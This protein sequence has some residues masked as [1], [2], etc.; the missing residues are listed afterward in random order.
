EAGEE[1]FSDYPFTYV[2]GGVMNTAT[3]MQ[4]L[5]LDAGVYFP[6]ENGFLGKALQQVVEEHGVTSL[7]FDSRSISASIVFRKKADRGFLASAD[8]SGFS[9]LDTVPSCRVLRIAG[10]KEAY[11]AKDF[12]HEC[13]SKGVLVS[14]SGSYSPRE[15]EM[16]GN[17]K[18][19]C[20]FLF[21]NE[22]EAQIAFKD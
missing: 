21:L 12:I 2:V 3:V 6:S 9:S 11:A 5:G 17:E 1:I 18:D 16:L 7:P 8:F 4:G 14:V 15:L 13:R 10:L 22:T 20:D 19:F